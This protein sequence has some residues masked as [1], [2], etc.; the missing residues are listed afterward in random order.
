MQRKE[1]MILQKP[2]E[3]GFVSPE[4][5]ENTENEQVEGV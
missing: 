3:V 2:V 4:N 1:V 5:L